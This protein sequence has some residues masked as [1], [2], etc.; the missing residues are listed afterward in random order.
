MPEYTF[1][2]FIYFDTNI[3]SH[4]VKNPHQVSELSDYLKDH[5][6]TM[7]IGVGQFAELADLKSLH[8]DLAK[9]LVSVPTGILKNADEIMAEEVKAHPKN[10]SDTLLTYGLNAILLEED[11][12]EKLIQFL[13][14]DSLAEARSDQKLNAKQMRGR[15]IGLKSNFP[16]SKSGKY[17]RKQADEFATYQVMQWLM[18]DHQDFLKKMQKDITKFHHEVFMSIRIFAYVLFYKYYLGQREPKRLSDFGDFFHLFPI[19]YCEIAVMERDLCNI[20]N[21]IK[22][23]HDILFSTQIYNIDFLQEFS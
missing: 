9:F 22:K 14:S 20:L 11:G 13:R 23:N 3:V 5:G 7:G 15:I 12:L 8:L 17:T 2:K 21:Q 1:S 10:R 6:L 16:P 19:P 18:Y 4:F